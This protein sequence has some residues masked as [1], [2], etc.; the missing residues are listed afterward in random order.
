MSCSLFFKSRKKYNH[1]YRTRTTCKVPTLYV[2]VDVY[3]TLLML[4]PLTYFLWTKWTPFRRRYF[5]Y[6][7]ASM[8]IFV[9]QF[10]FHWTLFLRIQ[11]GSY[12][13]NTFREFA[14]LPFFA[15]IFSRLV[16][17]HV[18]L[19][20]FI[21]KWFRKSMFNHI[22][23]NSI[24]QQTS[25]H[26]DNTIAKLYSS[27]GRYELTLCSYI[28]G[29]SFYFIVGEEIAGHWPH[30]TL[31]TNPK[32]LLSFM[33]VTFNKFISLWS[34]LVAVSLSN[35]RISFKSLFCITWSLLM[36]VSEQLQ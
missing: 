30:K 16:C 29:I 10:K 17:R 6:A 21:F 33:C 11:S 31:F 27:L 32:T 9:F 14:P 3:V 24:P 7:F 34:M 18:K 36:C 12:D 19:H 25:F 8:K 2:Y 4:R 35:L 26:F 1:A 5:S 28:V 23:V 13:R 15:L 22:F 20:K